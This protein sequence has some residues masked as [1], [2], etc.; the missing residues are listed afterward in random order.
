MTVP[1]PG[2]LKKHIWTRHTK[3]SDQMTS[4]HDGPLT[5][6]EK[7]PAIE[8]EFLSQKGPLFPPLPLFPHHPTLCRPFTITATLSPLVVVV[9]LQNPN[10][11]NP[12]PHRGLPPK[13]KPLS[14][15]NP[16]DPIPP[17]DPI[18]PNDQIPT[19]S[20]IRYDSPTAIRRSSSGRACGKVRVLG[21]DGG[22]VG[23]ETVVATPEEVRAVGDE[24]NLVGE[25]GGE[26]G[27]GG[28]GGFGGGAGGAAEDSGG[29]EDGVEGEAGG[30]EV[31]ASGFRRVVVFCSGR[32]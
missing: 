26:G 5:Q 17:I 3:D 7:R 24:F 9:T 32:R 16:I 4:E 30:V 13:P 1:P 29:E 21:E 15:P 19:S 11:L 22:R 8:N 20:L 10:P 23:V 14:H 6:N 12:I 31:G 2:L 18:N 25:Y 28:G 27:P